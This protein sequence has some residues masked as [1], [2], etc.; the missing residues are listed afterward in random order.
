MILRYAREG[1]INIKVRKNNSTAM[2]QK[3]TKHYPTKVSLETLPPDEESKRK[4]TQGNAEVFYGR[5]DLFQYCN[6][7]LPFNSTEFIGA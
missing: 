1:R 6:S 7:I 3:E 5:E 2:S 4:V